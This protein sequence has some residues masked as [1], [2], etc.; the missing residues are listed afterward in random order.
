MSSFGAVPL[1]L[2][3][4]HID[5]MVSSVNKCLQGIPGFSYAIAQTEQLLQCKGGCLTYMYMSVMGELQG[6]GYQYCQLKEEDLFI[7]LV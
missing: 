6:K 5:F 4:G 1:D 2:E 7:V 3:R